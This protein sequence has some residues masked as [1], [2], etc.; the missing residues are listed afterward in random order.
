M[1][2]L[3]L[4]F[5]SLTAAPVILVRRSD[6]QATGYVGNGIGAKWGRWGLVDKQIGA[7]D[8]SGYGPHLDAV[9]V[10][11]ERRFA[12]M[13]GYVGLEDVHYVVQAFGELGYV[14]V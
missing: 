14:L 11:G 8:R 3:W 13:H 1:E 2:V 7:G 10:W 9:G 4:G 6:L 12:V 5:R